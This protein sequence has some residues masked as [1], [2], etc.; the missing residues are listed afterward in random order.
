M[1]FARK[2]AIALASAAVALGVFM[3]VPA[4]AEDSSW[5]SDSSWGTSIIKADS[6]WGI[7]PTP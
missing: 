4:H 5:G 7:R 3:A 2:S 6:S 1:K